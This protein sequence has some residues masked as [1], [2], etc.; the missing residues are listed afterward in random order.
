MQIADN[1]VGTDVATLRHLGMSALY[2]IATMS[3][4]ERTQPHTIPSTGATKT[5]D[6]MTVRELR[7]VKKALKEAEERATQAEQNYEGIRQ[8]RNRKKSPPDGRGKV[9]KNSIDQAQPDGVSL[10]CRVRFRGRPE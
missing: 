3:G 4:S 8:T 7:E 5:T 1:L 2:E 9:V 6:E 10:Q